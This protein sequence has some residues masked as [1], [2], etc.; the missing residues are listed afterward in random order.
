MNQPIRILQ[1]FTIL[2]HG[3]TETNMMNY[4]RKLDRTKFQFDF[5][6]HREEKGAYED[7]IIALGGRIH[8]FLPITASN[9]ITYQ[10]QI[11]LFFDE[12]SYEII[13][14]Q[15]SELG[16]FI[17]KEAH[18]RK[19]KVIIAH[20]HSSPKNPSKSFIRWVLK[21][22]MMKYVNEYFTCGLDA[23][24]WLFGEKKAKKSF[25]MTN[26]IDSSMFAFNKQKAI[27][28]KQQLDAPSTKNYIHVGSFQN[29][30]NHKFLIEVF[31]ELLKLDQN[32]KLFLVGEG[33][34]KQSIEL[35]VNELGISKNVIFMGLRSDVNHLLQAMDVYLFPSLFEGL[36]VSL[37]EAQASGIQCF[38][39]DGIPKES[40]LIPENVTVISLKESAVNWANKIQLEN[41]FDKKNVMQKIIDKG[42]DINKNVKILENKYVQLLQKN[43]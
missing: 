3:G 32:Q 8:R 11:A 33:E 42:Y 4:Y 30:K 10:K 22:M 20:A 6:V 39:S 34:L 1:L 43:Q 15:C 16:F 35:K 36:P 21:K 13:H 26:S 19:V 17:Y 12:N 40:I 27:E 38:I 24:N 41:T 29:V 7:E 9:L 25:T 28:M 37:V 31:N 18:K 5:I 23:S 2:N 14:G